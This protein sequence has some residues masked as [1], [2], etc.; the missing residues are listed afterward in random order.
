MQSYRNTV[1][2]MR[3]Y[4][5]YIYL[6]VV[7]CIALSMVGRTKTFRGI[8]MSDGLSD[9]LVN[10]IY[11]DAAGF[12]WMGTDNS[13]DRFDGVNIKSYPLEGVDVKRRRVN[14]LVETDSTHLWIGNGAGLWVFDYVTGKPQRILS[15][16]LDMPIWSILM[17][18]AHSLYIGS[19]KGLYIADL[20]GFVRTGKFSDIQVKHI[21]VDP[22]ILSPANR[23]KSILIDEAGMVWLATSKGLY[24]YIPENESLQS[25]VMSGQIPREDEFRAM[26]RIDET[27][28]LGTESQGLFLYDMRNNIF[29]RFID[30][31]SGV[32][33]S[34]STDGKDNLYVSTDGNGVCCISHAKKEILYTYRHDASDKSSIRSNSV[35]SFLVDREGIFWIG[36]YSA[37]LD[38]SLYQNDLFD[39]YAYPPFFDSNN[40]SVRSFYI[41]G[42]EKLIGTRDGLYYINEQAEQVRVFK[43][44]SLR[45]DL[46]LS[47]DFYHGKYYIG[48]Y[49]GGLYVLDS[50]TGLLEDFTADDSFTFRKGHIFN[51]TPDKNGNLWFAT[52]EGVYRYAGGNHKLQLFNS[53]NSQM[54]EGNVYDIFFDSTGKGWI[55]TDRGLCIYDVSSGSIRSNIFPEQFPVSEK[56]RMI[57][58]GTDKKLYFLPDKG[59]V[60]VS[61]LTM[62]SFG[63]LS[64]HTNRFLGNAYKSVVED[65][66]EKVWLGCD[67]GLL[68]VHKD[69]SNVNAFGFN[70]GLPDQA[71]MNNAVY[72]DDNGTL[73]FGNS[74][75]LVFVRPEQVDSM[76]K[77]PYKLVFTDIF[78]NGRSL[79]DAKIDYLRKEQTLL[80]N[81][82]ENTISF[83]FVNLSYSDPLMMAYE[84]KL[85]GYMADWS[86]VNGQNEMSFYDLPSGKYTFRVRVPGDENSE[87]YLNFRIKAVSSI[88]TWIFIPAFA[89][90]LIVISFMYVKLYRRKKTDI[91]D[92]MDNPVQQV[93]TISLEEGE[94]TRK[95]DEKKELMP[96]YPVAVKNQ[97]NKSGER[98]YKSNRLSQKECKDL[99]EKLSA[100]MKSEKP[101]TNPDLKISDVA[102]ALGVSSP[103]MS[104]LF[105]QY[106]HQSYYDYMNEYRV[107]EFK[108]L[109]RKPEYKRYTLSALAELCGFSSRASFFRSFKKITGITPNEYISSI[110]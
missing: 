86:F 93:E 99:S 104:Y 63:H 64:I 106:I 30:V 77:V 16:T 38:Y 96:S 85:D 60:F 23:I 71:F 15:E 72:K 31:G 49:G 91:S 17:M 18:G 34:L 35:Y 32:I 50:I 22:N 24:S 26:A 102:Q 98:K 88:G 67:D 1:F 55:C 75:G 78:L 2:V 61:D 33:S 21:L 97:T 107:E 83:R 65:D 12:V 53:T 8:T 3:Q 11:K 70:D 13:L 108:R 39:V 92:R 90:L 44:P 48:T 80:L 84:Y 45:S 4:K 9:L 57:Y 95:T 69:G 103:L 41:N 54:P 42:K 100:Y 52:S 82:N 87:I 29:E 20:S 46:I 68:R 101:Y 10:V 28:Y 74:K 27:I 14:A 40:L 76:L 5:K 59:D 47:I 62:T 36:F 94:I 37:G 110:S 105:N 109:V 58:E 19:E 81:K 7:L 51:I 79:D 25:Y 66:N 43:M 89:I 6:L 56:F 73:W